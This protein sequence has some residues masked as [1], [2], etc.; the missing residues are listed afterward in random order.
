MRRRRGAKAEEGEEEEQGGE[1]G[2]GEHEQ[3]HRPGEVEHGKEGRGGGR[4]EERVVVV[5]LLL[6]LPLV[7]AC[8]GG[9]LL[10]GRWGGGRGGG[11]GSGHLW[12]EGVGRLKR[13]TRHAH[14]RRFFIYT[15]GSGQ[16][17][18]PAAKLRQGLAAASQERQRAGGV[19]SMNTNERNGR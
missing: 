16:A 17:G 3:Q 12:R 11:S 4:G 1:R 18:L 19:A 6:L 2:R 7:A 10:R 8:A 9:E 13:G 15:R 14:A 5:R